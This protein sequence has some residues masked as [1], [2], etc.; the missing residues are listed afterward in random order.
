MSNPSHSRWFDRPNNYYEVPGSSV[1][2]VSGYR[3][4]DRVIGVRSPTGANDFS[5]NPFVQNSSEAHPAS[6]T[7]GTGGPFLGGKARQGRDADHSPPSSAEVVNEL[8]LYRPIL[9]PQSL[10]WRVVGQLYF[11][12]IVMANGFCSTLTQGQSFHLTRT[13]G[14]ASVYTD[15]QILLSRVIGS[16]WRHCLKWKLAVLKFI[17]LW[18]FAHS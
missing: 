3:L 18:L 4:D 8:E 11:W 13:P 1:S 7:M 16:E 15:K 17:T 12:I 10:S 2:I 14:S 9:F 6:C 5:S